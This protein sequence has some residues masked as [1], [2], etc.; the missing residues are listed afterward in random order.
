VELLNKEVAAAKK[1]V[2]NDER[3]INSAKRR[4]QDLASERKRLQ[5]Q[6]A[7]AL[8]EALASGG[9]EEQQKM[10]KLEQLQQK[11]ASVEQEIAST[12]ANLEALQPQVDAATVEHRT[13]VDNVRRAEHDVKELDR[14]V[15]DLQ[16]AQ[17][18]GQAVQF[19]RKVPAINKAIADE[20]NWDHPPVGPLGMHVK[21]K[22]PSYQKWAKAVG[23]HLGSSL[24]DYVVTSPKDKQLFDKILRKCSALGEHNT[25]MLR[26]HARYGSAGQTPL[27]SPVGVLTMEQIVQ[28]DDDLAYN[29][30]LEA[31]ELEGQVLFDSHQEAERQVFGGPKGNLKLKQYVKQSYDPTGSF[32]SVKNGNKFTIAAKTRQSGVQFGVSTVESLERANA[33]LW[34]AKTRAN[35]V[36]AQER[37]AKTKAQAQHQAAKKLEMS[38]QSLEKGQPGRQREISSLKEEL[39]EMQDSTAVDTSEWEAQEQNIVKDLEENNAAMEEAKQAKASAEEIVAQKVL[40]RQEYEKTAK[41]LGQQMQAAEAELSGVMK[42][43]KDGKEGLDKAQRKVDEIVEANKAVHAAVEEARAVLAEATEA[44]RTH[45]TN[46][47]GA[48]T[49]MPVTLGKGKDRD[50]VKA[51]IK[52][53]KLRKEDGLKTLPKGERNVEEAT[54]KAFTARATYNEKVANVKKVEDNIKLLE[55]DVKKRLKKWKKFRKVISR[56]T[57]KRFDH[58]LNQKGQSGELILD[59]KAETLSL[60]VQKDSRDSQ[61]QIGNVKQLSGGERSY[62]TLSLL[63]ALG[64]CVECPFRIMDEFDVFMDAVSRK[65]ALQQLIDEGLQ[66]KHRQFVFIT[67]QDL[68]SITP[69]PEVRIIKL[70]NPDRLVEGQAT[71]A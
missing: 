16:D 44:A 5:K 9:A 47:M 65:I 45:T 21:L 60:T 71:L 17:S 30:L 28:I 50:Y 11:C 54:A 32:T 41:G 23:T 36:K 59:H 62:A 34:E 67:P 18:G 6:I 2:Q 53:L 40:A 38:L 31:R 39:A 55:L 1:P 49:E 26:P 57:D 33:D 66:N 14:E 51:K 56:V 25:I 7:D 15:K 48:G 35:E 63:V 13:C 52:A 70:Q 19:G 69:R 68:S 58:T 8:S 10:A 46:H 4:S 43:R 24:K 3:D 27:E 61:S 22:D 29:A 37:D 12:K 20:R 42:A 64:E